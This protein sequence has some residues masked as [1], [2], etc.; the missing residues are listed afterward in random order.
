[1]NREQ[2]IELL[3]KLAEKADFEAWESL[4]ENENKYLEYLLENKRQR[5][6]ET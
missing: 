5:K 1:M 6:N 4:T 3:T 2:Q